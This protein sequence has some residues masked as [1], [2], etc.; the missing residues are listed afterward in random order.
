MMG[1]PASSALGQEEAQMQVDDKFFAEFYRKHVAGSKQPGAAVA[2]IGYLE[3]HVANGAE[4]VACMYVHLHPQPIAAL[5]LFLAK[6]EFH[7]QIVP[8]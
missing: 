5:A 8:D 2:A 1:A 4:L 6:T 3:K 7:V